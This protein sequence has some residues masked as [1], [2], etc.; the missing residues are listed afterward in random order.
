MEQG[1]QEIC[2]SGV[3]S[4]ENVIHVDGKISP[5]D[6]IDVINTE[7]ALADLESVEKAL[8]RHI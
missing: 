1:E 8:Q 3:E 4:N 5:V 2:H 6:D 7:L